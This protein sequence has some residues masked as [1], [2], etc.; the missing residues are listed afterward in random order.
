MPLA[1]LAVEVEAALEPKLMAPPAAQVTVPSPMPARPPPSA[2][3]RQGCCGLD[4]GRA[5]IKRQRGHALEYSA[6]GGRAEDG[7]AAAVQCRAPVPG[8][9]LLPAQ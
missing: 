5:G 7:K 1:P 2:G 4:G 8:K 3:T 6:G 9:M